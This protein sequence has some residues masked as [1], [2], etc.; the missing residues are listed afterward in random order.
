LISKAT[1]RSLATAT[2]TSH[3][4]SLSGPSSGTGA[5]KQAL[6][7]LQQLAETERD[8]KAER[9]SAKTKR[10]LAEIKHIEVKAKLDEANTDRDLAKRKRDL[11][12]TER[13]LAKAERDLAKAERDLAETK[14]DLAETKHI[15]AK[16]KRD[17]IP[18]FMKSLQKDAETELETALHSWKSAQRHLD[19][20]EMDFYSTVKS[21]D[22]AIEKLKKE[23][24]RYEEEEKHFK[25]IFEGKC[26]ITILSFFLYLSLD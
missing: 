20:M 21:L 23:E 12:E 16:A 8:A 18:G 9:D 2:T 24:K 7:I 26:L 6:Q 1:A 14:R 10:N 5:P 17:A 3:V 11:A 13:D 19:I 22:E 25:A 15:E 4:S